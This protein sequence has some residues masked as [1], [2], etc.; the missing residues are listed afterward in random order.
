MRG[1][2]EV[3][4]HGVMFYGFTAGEAS[5]TAIET[6]SS[7]GQRVDVCGRKRAVDPERR[8]FRALANFDRHGMSGDTSLWARIS[9]VPLE[10]QG[11]IGRLPCRSLQARFFLW[12]RGVLRVHLIKGKLLETLE[13]VA[14][15]RTHSHPVR[16]PKQQQH[17][18]QEQ[19]PCDHQPEGICFFKI[20]AGWQ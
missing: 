3:R 16:C 14:D 11:M 4:A 6:A 10:K 18:V 13:H 17:P 20:T 9:P 2:R 12:E 15:V 1:A 7:S 8:A 19:Q 5:S